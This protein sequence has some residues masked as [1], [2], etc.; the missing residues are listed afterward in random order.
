MGKF[1]LYSLLLFLDLPVWRLK[2][3]VQTKSKPT[4]TLFT[5]LAVLYS[6][7]NLGLDNHSAL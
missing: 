7:S 4:Y 1:T 5:E 3:F 6:K 2:D